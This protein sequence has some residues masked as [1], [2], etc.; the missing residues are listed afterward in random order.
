[1]PLMTFAITCLPEAFQVFS[2]K[3]YR[4]SQTFT[5]PIAAAI[6]IIVVIMK[7]H[8]QTDTHKKTQDKIPREFT[9]GVKEALNSH[10]TML[11]TLKRMKVRERNLYL[12]ST[13][14]ASWQ[15]QLLISS[16]SFALNGQSILLP[17]WQA[18]CFVACFLMGNDSACPQL[19]H[20]VHNSSLADSLGTVLSLKFSICPL[21]WVFFYISS[22][23]AELLFT[24]LAHLLILCT[25]S[26]SSVLLLKYDKFLYQVT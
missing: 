26:A 6:V 9:E 5:T 15:L 16:P 17:L 23:N 12:V 4:K 25:L 1:M 24:P 18:V 10:Q 22:S 20:S 11:W 13:I 21:I 8:M 14:T 3:T 2:A 7:E 19:C